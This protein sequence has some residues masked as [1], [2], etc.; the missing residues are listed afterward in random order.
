MSETD[1]EHRDSRKEYVTL[2]NGLFSR[3]FEAQPFDAISS[4]LRVGGMSDANWDTFEESRNAFDDF[5]WLLEKA[6]NERS[7][8]SHTR[9]SLLMYC[10]AI[11]MTA[12][13]EILANLLRCLSKKHYIVQP[14]HHLIRRRKKSFFLPWIPPSAKT[15]FKEIKDV[16]KEANEIKLIETIDSFFDEKV[17]N[18]FSHSDYVLTDKYFRY[19]NGGHP[20]QISLEKLGEL[21]NVCFGFYGAFLSLH[22]NWLLNFSKAKKYHKFAQYEVLELLSNEE[23][24]LYGFNVHF[25]NGS[26]ATYSRR[27]TGIN[28]TNLRFE[29]DGGINFMAGNLDALEPVWKI[30]GNSVEDWNSLE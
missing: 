27:K 16:A 28:A 23:E 10:Q 14:F 29:N 2:L 17:R 11:E 1:I 18:A 22:K 7:E 24:G 20:Q 15:K 12:P 4:I 13:H 30:N 6:I 9:I 21:I 26:K 3:A 5:N 25:S 19:I 8:T